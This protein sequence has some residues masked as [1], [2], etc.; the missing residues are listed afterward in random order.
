[1][2]VPI[3]IFSIVLVITSVALALFEEV[4]LAIELAL[5]L[6]GSPL[7]ALNFLAASPGLDFP[8]FAQ[9]DQ[10]FL[11]A[12]H[13]SLPQTFRFSLGLAEN[14]LCRLFCRRLGCLLTS[15][16]DVAAALTADDKKNRTGN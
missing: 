13:S 8:I 10:L 7:L 1:M 12:E 6:V 4:V 9:L 14:F 16:L 3:L 2:T 5:A 15:E 11:A